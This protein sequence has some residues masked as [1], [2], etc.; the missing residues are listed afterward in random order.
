[1]IYRY[2]STL[3]WFLEIKNE[4]SRIKILTGDLKEERLWISNEFI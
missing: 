4:N 2:P 3:I 1:M